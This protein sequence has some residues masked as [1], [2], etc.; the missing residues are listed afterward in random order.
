MFERMQ[1]AILASVCSHALFMTSVAEQV[2]TGMAVGD[3]YLSEQGFI[4]YFFTSCADRSN[5]WPSGR[6]KLQLHV[7]MPVFLST[8]QCAETQGP[9]WN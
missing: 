6:G 9:H 3:P 7:L 8:D 1:K 2:L 5:L 4:D